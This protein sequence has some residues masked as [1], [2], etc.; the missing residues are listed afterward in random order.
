M[1]KLTT[2]PK[3]FSDWE[4]GDDYEVAKLLGTGSYGSVAE[5]T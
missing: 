4:V 1:Q 3:N 5:A 2:L